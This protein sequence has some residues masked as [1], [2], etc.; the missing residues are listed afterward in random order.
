MKTNWGCRTRQC[1]KFYAEQHLFVWIV[2]P[3]IHK[4]TPPTPPKKKK[5]PNIPS[6]LLH[7]FFFFFFGNDTNNGPWTGDLILH[8]DL[9]RGESIIWARAHQLPR[10]SICN[11]AL[12]NYESNKFVVDLKSS[13]RCRMCSIMSKALIIDVEMF[14][15]YLYILQHRLFITFRVRAVQEWS[16]PESA[17]FKRL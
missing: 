16:V 1:L 14:Y 9:I 6:V 3:K 7:Q 17:S 8:L 13:G 12:R 10:T 5:K 15:I 4:N 11:I 2:S